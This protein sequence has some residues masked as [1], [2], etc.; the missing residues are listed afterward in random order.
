MAAVVLFALIAAVLCASCR[1]DGDSAAAP[2]TTTATTAATSAPATSASTAVPGPPSATGAQGGARDDRIG[3]PAS[4]RVATDAPTEGT[5]FNE[6]L[7][8]ATDP[9]AHVIV[10]VDCAGPH[11]AEVFL[12]TILP[13]PAGAPYPGDQ[14]IDRESYM[15]CLSR[16]QTYVGT[17]YATSALRA[18]LLRPTDTTWAQ[19][20]RAVVCSLYDDRL[21]P[22]VGSA[23]GSAR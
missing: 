22:L 15:A 1:S 8:A 13:E 5:C 7:D 3:P 17:P 14:A 19:G 6:V 16:F 9:P 11:D 4:G 20:D 21:V 12:R 2:S 18:S 10:A 23:R